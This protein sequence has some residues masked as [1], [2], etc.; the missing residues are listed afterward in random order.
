MIPYLMALGIF[1]IG[2]GIGGFAT[3][4]WL[5]SVYR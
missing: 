3:L 2:A 5:N 4:M 1:L